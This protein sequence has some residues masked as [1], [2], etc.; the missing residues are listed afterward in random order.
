[1]TPRLRSASRTAASATF[2]LS[3]FPFVLLAVLALPALVKAH[4]WY[5]W[6]CCSGYDCQKI[7]AKLVV[8][9][10]GGYEI[11]IGPGDHKMAKDWPGP[12][13]FFFRYSEMKP[14]PDG[15]WHLCITH[16]DVGKCLFGAVGGS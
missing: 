11:T 6:E 7:D 13:V 10:N 14:S 1:M 4:E 9:K 5:P 2:R 16:G 12:R 8:E 3:V 15:D